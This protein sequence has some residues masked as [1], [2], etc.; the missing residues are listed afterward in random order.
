MPIESP[1]TYFLQ[2]GILG[3]IIVVLGGVI[4][5]Q[6]RRLDKKDS[7]IKELYKSIDNVQEKRLTDNEK[8]ITNIIT[9]GQG[10]TGA[11]GSVQ[12][13]IDAVA[14]VQEMRGKV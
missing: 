14:R 11:I 8:H 12:K 10:L 5:W 1:E 2:Q 3:I 9:L 7:E 6:Q 13:S 4:L